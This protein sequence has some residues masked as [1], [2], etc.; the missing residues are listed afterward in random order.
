MGELIFCIGYNNRLSDIVVEP[1]DILSQMWKSVLP[2]MAIPSL[3][4][5]KKHWALR[6]Q[7]AVR[8][9]RDGEVWGVRNFYI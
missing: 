7:K 6:P 2:D 9:I 5:K 1:S 8:L 3:L 4:W